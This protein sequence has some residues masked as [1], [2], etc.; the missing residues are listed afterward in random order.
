MNLYY[1]RENILEVDFILEKNNELIAIEVKSNGIAEY[2][3]LEAFKK[4]YGPQ[5][6][7]LVGVK[8]IPVDEFL[9]LNPGDL[10]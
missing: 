3:G 6:I 4:M 5:K 1:W 8:G 10:Y 7:I 9:Q 2:R